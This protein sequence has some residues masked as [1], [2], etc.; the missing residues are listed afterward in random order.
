MSPM[1]DDE[2]ALSRAL[3]GKVDHMNDAPLGLDDVQGAAQGVR[4]RRRIAAGAGLAAAAVILVPTAIVASGGLGRDDSAPGPVAST[5]TPTTE[6]VDSPTSEPS[7]TEAPDPDV[8]LPFDVSDLPTGPAP[9]IEWSDG[10]DIHRADGSVVAGVL[11]PTADG[12][13]PMGSGWVVA[14]HDEGGG[15][16]QWIPASGMSTAQVYDLDGDLATSPGG[17][18]V[19]WAE[20]DGG[21][22]L[23]QRDGD[24]TLE[25][26]PITA[27]GAYDAV[28]VGTEDCKEGRTTESGCAIFVNTLGE[29]NQ[30]WVTTSHGIV[31]RYDE[32]MRTM[33]AWSDGAYAGITEVKD[34]LSTCSA[35]RATATLS[36]VWD[37]CD[38]R[39]IGFA[40]SGRHVLGVGSVGD[41]FGDGQVAVLDATDG[42]VVADL[43][44]DE[45]HQTSAVQLTWE[46]ASH[47]LAVTYADGAWAVVRIGLD[48]TMEY[49]VPPREGSDFERPFFLQS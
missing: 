45:Q 46:D 19:A 29:Q 7:A 21:V 8:T 33:T 25:M 4:R 5:T 12:F 27:P 3:H 18:V 11:P 44:S 9:A 39:L 48:G 38:H 2:Q 14:T 1:N 15:F 13:A 40:P 17:E 36:T 16:A 22:R 24:E 31:D 20:P 42:R 10:R 35:V 49:A 28:A 26:S 43:R 41:G 47:A 37:T 32:E 30:V 6:P 34:D 23:V